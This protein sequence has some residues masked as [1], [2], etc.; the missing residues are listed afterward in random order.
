MSTVTYILWWKERSLQAVYRQILCS[1]GSQSALSVICKHEGIRQSPYEA[2]FG[3][4]AKRF[5]A[6]SFYLSEQIVNTETEEQ[7]EEIANTFET[8]EQLKETGNTS[9]KNVSGGHTENHIP[10]KIIEDDL[11]STTP[12][13]Q[14]L[15]EKQELISKEKGPRKRIFYY[16]QQKF[17]EPHKKNLLLLKLVILYEYKSLMWTVVVQITEMYLGLLL[18]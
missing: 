6:S 14:V 8:Q 18:E 17:Y 4:K 3:V 13:H 9:E 16:K 1:A 2:T 12:S 7:L 15:T 10:K 5:I 11:E